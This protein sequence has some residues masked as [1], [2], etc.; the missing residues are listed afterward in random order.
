MDGTGPPDLGP[1]E[2]AVQR[3]GGD[4]DRTAVG[5]RQ[6]RDDLRRMRRDH[7]ALDGAA[8]WIAATGDSRRGDDP[9]RRSAAVRARGAVRRGADRVA[10]IERAAVLTPER[11]H[12][13]ETVASIGPDPTV[14]QT[15]GPHQ[16]SDRYGPVS[17]SMRL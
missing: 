1:G 2:R 16:T 14:R 4:R 3:V 12:R 6:R 13:H 10:R 15:P 5:A 7:R 11:V 9:G 17:R 8:V